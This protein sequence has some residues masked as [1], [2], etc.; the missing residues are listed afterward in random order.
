MNSDEDDDLPLARFRPTFGKISTP[1]L[2]LNVD[3][4]ER[5][6]LSACALHQDCITDVREECVK[7]LRDT[8]MSNIACQQNSTITSQ[9][10]SA[11]CR[12]P[13]KLLRLLSQK[14]VVCPVQQ[15]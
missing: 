15:L 11:D 13:D 12:E 5:V 9:I 1:D 2:Q 8:G 3:T 7:E 10:N 6:V 4:S 14:S